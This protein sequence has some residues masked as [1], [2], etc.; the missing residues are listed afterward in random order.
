MR[1]VYPTE[2][3]PSERRAELAVSLARNESEGL[4]LAITAADRVTLHNVQVSLGLAD[5]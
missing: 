1:K 2:F 3:P 5:E 4:Q